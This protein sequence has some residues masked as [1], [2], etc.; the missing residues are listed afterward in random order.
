MFLIV[1]ILLT[2]NFDKQ[3]KK[4]LLILYFFLNHIFRLLEL[5]LAWTKFENGALKTLCKNLPTQIIRLNLSG[6]QREIDDEGMKRFICFFEFQFLDLV[7]I[8]TR[9]P[10]MIELDLSD[11]TKITGRSIKTFNMLSNIQSI[12]ISRCYGIE[13]MSLL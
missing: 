4:D 2:L 9:C 5:N 11:C 6:M 12:S 7:S 3:R 13:P 8:V 1:S 10:E